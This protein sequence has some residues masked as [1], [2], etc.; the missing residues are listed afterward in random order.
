MA[1]DRAVPEGVRFEVVGEC[2]HT[3]ARAGL[4]HT[5]RGTIETPVFMP[6]GTQ[7][8][9]KGLT[10]R[11]LWE[12]LGAGIILANTY[13]LYL[14]PGHEVVQ[15]LGG[16]Q[17]FMSWP[18]A[19]LTDSGGFQVFSLAGL[20]RVTEDGVIFRSHLDGSE[21]VFTPESTVD[22]Q[23][24]LGSDVMMVL[25][26]CT[27]YPASRERARASME[28]T[29]RWA[30]RAFRH[31]RGGGLEHRGGA[32]FPIVQGSMFADLRREC[33]ERLVALDA[34]GYAVG[35]LSVGEPRGMSYEMV[36]ASEPLLPR[37]KPRYVMGVGMLAELGEYVALGVDMMDCV[38]P[39]RN[40][41]NGYLFTSEG[42]LVI[43]NA[44]WAR[45]G[46]PVDENCPCYT[47][48]NFSRGYLRHLFL[49]REMLFGTLATIHNV[50]TYLD[51]MKRIRE[52]ILL[53]DL[54]EYL[55]LIRAKDEER[56]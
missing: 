43:K 34:P 7:A 48:R 10:P 8:S 11:M 16:V 26:E 17:G 35:G 41:R 37:D 53:G 4:L 40:A 47:C 27:E 32:L 44:Q 20:R 54:P 42:P 52:A 2:P 15:E 22:V 9:V 6:V 19:V 14:R 18:G 49:A 50:F 23:R 38:L 25:D 5:A 31:W 1:P 30:E 36:E 33:A 12:E 51:R 56:S 24:A 45:D 55:A 39:T 3:R 46:R 28:T 21:H 13:H 29:L